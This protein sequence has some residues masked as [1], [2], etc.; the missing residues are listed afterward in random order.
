MTPAGT[1]P[2]MDPLVRLAFLALI[3]LLVLV[4]ALYHIWLDRSSARAR[5]RERH[6]HQPATSPGEGARG[7]RNT[8]ATE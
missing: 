8:E 7:A 1:G 5:E 2:A 4:I 6:G 3:A